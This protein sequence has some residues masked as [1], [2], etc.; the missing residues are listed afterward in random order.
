MQRIINVLPQGNGINYDYDIKISNDGKKI[1]VCILYDYMDK[2]GLYRDVFPFSV[3]DYAEAITLHF[4]N[5][6]STQYR[7]IRQNGLREHLEVLFKNVWKQ[8]I[9]FLLPPVTVYRNK[10]DIEALTPIQRGFLATLAEDAAWNF[11]DDT[12]YAENIPDYIHDKLDGY[13]FT[14]RNIDAHSLE[15]SLEIINDAISNLTLETLYYT[16]D[17]ELEDLG[18]E[19]FMGIVYGET[20]NHHAKEIGKNDKYWKFAHQSRIIAQDIYGSYRIFVE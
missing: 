11:K 8:V 18:G 6:T 5:L 10:T 19:I 16:T 7:K 12:T 2:N 1:T 4:H 14:A 13:G 17:N 15:N 3:T 20:E 9:S